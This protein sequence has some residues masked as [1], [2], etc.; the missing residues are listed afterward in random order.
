MKASP[1]PAYLIARFES[2]RGRLD[3][4]RVP[5]IASKR[6]TAHLIASEESIKASIQP[7]QGRRFRRRLADERRARCRHRPHGETR[8][9]FQERG[10]AQ[11]TTVAAAS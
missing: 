4:R 5:S 6:R 2:D 9:L 11:I 1:R 8:A 10:E 7:F 3:S